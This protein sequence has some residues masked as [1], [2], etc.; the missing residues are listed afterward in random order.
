ML[1]RVILFA[2][3]PTSKFYALLGLIIFLKGCFAAKTLHNRRKCFARD[4]ATLEV[5]DALMAEAL[6]Q[7]I[8]PLL[9]I[10]LQVQLKQPH[11]AHC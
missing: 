3:S 10:R 8:Q 11:L 6:T 7:K 2:L 4:G 9:P 5:E 1:Q